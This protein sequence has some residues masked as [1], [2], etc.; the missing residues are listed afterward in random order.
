MKNRLYV[1]F[2]IVLSIGVFSGCATLIDGY[3]GEVEIYNAPDDLEVM[4]EEGKKLLLSE[5][6]VNESFLDSKDQPAIHYQ[7]VKKG[8]KIVHLP[9]KRKYTLVLKTE[10]VERKVELNPKIGL[11]WFILDIL[12]F[13]FPIIP[14]AI[15]GNWYY[16]SDIDYTQ[17]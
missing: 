12:G 10:G 17:I 4:T 5:V 13:A 2:I 9:V 1:F 16:Y 11:G 3:E 14:D 8:T 15:T 7:Y 6:L